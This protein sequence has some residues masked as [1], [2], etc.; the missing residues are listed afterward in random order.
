MNKKAETERNHLVLDLGCDWWVKKDLFYHQR[1]HSVRSHV[2]NVAVSIA[3]H[4]KAF[5]HSKRSQNNI[6][7]PYTSTKMNEMSWER[8]ESPRVGLSLWLGGEK[9]FILPP[10]AAFC[11]SH[12][13]NIAVSIVQV[14]TV[15]PRAWQ[16]VSL[17]QD[18]V[19]RHQTHQTYNKKERSQLNLELNHLALY[20]GL[21]WGETK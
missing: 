11:C 21:V 13:I 3:S 16:K 7:T 17:I 6:Q 14:I 20:R 2:I 4:T 8:E 10:K 5:C 9:R 1:R 18:A 12:M 19:D 15:R